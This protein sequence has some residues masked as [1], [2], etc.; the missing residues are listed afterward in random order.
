MLMVQE[1]NHEDC[2]DDDDNDDDDN[3]DDDIDNDDDNDDYDNMT[4]FK[5]H[6]VTSPSFLSTARALLSIH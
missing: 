4:R 6:L 1:S 3:D 5:Q 2:N